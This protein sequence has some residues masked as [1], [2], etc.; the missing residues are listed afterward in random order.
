MVLL[1][2]ISLIVCLIVVSMHAIA[3]IMASIIKRRICN[4]E[5]RAEL[6]FNIKNDYILKSIISIAMCIISLISGNGIVKSLIC[7]AITF[8]LIFGYERIRSN[9]TKKRVLQD[10]LNVVECLRVQISSGISLD[11]A[12]RNIQELCKNREFSQELANLYLEYQLSKFTVNNSAKELQEKFNYPEIRMFI[13]AINQQTQ[14]TSA[15][16]ALDNLIEVL[17]DKYIGYMEDV[18]RSKSVIMII[19]VCIVVLNLATMSVYP[20]IL[21]ANEA[22]KVMLK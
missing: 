17:K 14:S 11:I 22:L 21:E 18:T 7:G 12:L 6:K 5:V 13:S 19:G 3:I 8:A 9:S 20:L 10:L 4:E 16:E 2:R 1:L 15:L